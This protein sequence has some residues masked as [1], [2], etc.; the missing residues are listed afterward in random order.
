[1]S[2][3]SFRAEAPRRAAAAMLRALGGSEVA[4]RVAEPMGELDTRGLGLQQYDV[5]EIK[6]GPAIVRQT[7]PVPDAQWEVVLP[8]TEIEA[9]LG[10]DPG[11]I[12]T[13]LRIGTTML[14]DDKVLRIA[15]VSCEQFAGRE[16]LYRITLGA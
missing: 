6:L 13:V 16:Y 8:A 1:M 3:S 15:A 14:W 9:K 10:P 2:V 11:T 12:A 7:K 5:S 4:I